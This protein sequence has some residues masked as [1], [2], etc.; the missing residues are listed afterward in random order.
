[1]V[2]KKIIFIK[3]LNQKRMSAFKVSRNGHTYTKGVADELVEQ[4][5]YAIDIYKSDHRTRQRTSVQIGDTLYM[6]RGNGYWIGTVTSDWLQMPMYNGEYHPFGFFHSVK[7]K[8]K[9][10]L[11]VDHDEW[12][13]KVNW[14][15]WT[16]F[17]PTNAQNVDDS[18]G[19]MMEMKK[20]LDEGFNA[21]TIKPLPSRATA[22]YVIRKSIR[23]SKKIHSAF[24]KN[25][26]ATH[27]Q[28]KL[29]WKEDAN[30]AKATKK[31]I[32]SAKKAAKVD[33]KAAKQR[34][35]AKRAYQTEMNRRK[36]WEREIQSKFEGIFSPPVVNKLERE[37]PVMEDSLEV[38]EWN[39]NGEFYLV[40]RNTLLI[41]SD[42][43]EEIGKW[44]EGTTTRAPIPE[45]EGVFIC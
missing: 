12:V 42:D 11:D 34:N 40:C 8:R 25:L 29:K 38:E 43:G 13:C 2:S 23:E 22:A 41:Y 10:P 16:P 45:E 9:H 30:T 27:S 32:A 1:M 3:N 4:G 36:K 7:G 39:H 37:E 6:V 5:C 33:K 28:L 15:I 20:W 26:K 18:E 19:E 24:K 31:A 35:K 17:P 44:G 14:G 21:I